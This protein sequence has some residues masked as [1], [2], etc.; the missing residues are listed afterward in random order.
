MRSLMPSSRPNILFLTT[1]QQR[2]D[3]LGINSNGFVQTPNLDALAREGTNLLR[4]YVNNPLCMPSRASL[5]TGKYPRNHGV[6]CNGIPL[7]ES[8]PNIAHALGSAGY[9]TGNLGK[10][11]FLPHSGRDY[12]EPHPDYG[13]HVVVNADE[14]G[15]YP[16]AYI[17][18]IRSV[19]PELEEKVRVPIPGVEPRDSFDRW[20]FDAPEELSYSAW[21]ADETIKFIDSNPDRP[22]FA[23]AGLYL[24]HA[25]CNPTRRWFDLYSDVEIPPPL[26]RENELNDKP[27]VFRELAERFVPAD[28]SEWE[29]FR[30]YY[31][32]SCSMV[33]HHCGRVI[34]HL[35]ETGRLDNTL[36]V[37]YSDHGEMAGDH[38]L[39]AKHQ[40]NYDSVIHVPAIVRYPA[41]VPAGSEVE[42]IIEAVDLMPTILEAVGAD[43]P[44]S[45]DG[46][47]RWAA[48]TGDSEAG[49]NSVLV[50]FATPEGE[51]CKTLLTTT[52]KYWVNQKGEELLFDLRDDPNEF[53][54]R[55]GDAAAAGDLQDM[56]ARL[57]QKLISTDDRS[58]ERTAQY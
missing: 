44:R 16:D 25:P 3:C 7:S 20:I 52:H 37:F 41:A 30:R 38:R 47:S 57:L 34:E 17:Q 54:N 2:F 6:T 35:R 22:W 33:D 39:M 1:D 31:Y 51:N 23:I 32:A 56:R 11:H 14:P 28:D 27:T 53:V 4:F 9:V 43:T 48:V 58:L 15:C 26:L 12:T 49:P 5:L 36:V 18:W 42:A 55:A 29:D 45:V 40:T 10:L 50:E 21:V 8:I 19:A 46:H 24:P 13:F